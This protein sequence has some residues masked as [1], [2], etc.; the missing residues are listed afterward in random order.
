MALLIS[1]TGLS[2]YPPVYATSLPFIVNFLPF[3]I[4]VD[5]DIILSI[6]M[7]VHVAIGARFYLTRKKI[8]HWSANLSLVLITFALTLTVF[9]VDLPPGLK[10]SGISIGG[11]FYDFEPNEIDSVRPDLFQNGSF[12]AFDILVH[13]NSTGEIDL[14]YHFNSS[15][16]TYVIDSINGNSD[17]WW[18]HLYYSGG[19]IENN[20]VRMDHYPWKPGTRIIMY[21]ES[22]SYLNAAFSLFAEEV[23]RYTYN[24]NSIV[25]PRVNVS[26][27]SFSE[28]FYNITVIP[29]NL[30]NETFRV[31]VITAM[32]VIM[33]LGDLGYITYELTWHESF[34]GA[35]YVHSYFVSKTNTDEAVGRCGYLYDVSES[36]I[37]L[38]ADERILTSPESID[39]Y[40]GCV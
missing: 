24:N 20:E 17:N 15:M 8:N 9:F 1:F 35:S 5:F 26:G 37:W 28:E 38:S 14:N 40:W 21:H 34:R 16:D 39:F 6:F 3:T 22:E 27:Y 23:S 4:H 13:L 7:I 31:D 33:T 29:H 11:T 30:R 2:Y 32:D 12:S 19:N 25:I 18:Y 10:P 36:F